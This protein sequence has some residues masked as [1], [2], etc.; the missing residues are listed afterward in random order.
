[1]PGTNVWGPSFWAL[2][3]LISF[4]YPDNPSPKDI[5]IALT[6]IK[7]IYYVL[8]CKLC[9]DHYI[10]NLKT[11]PLKPCD[12]KSKKNFVL[13]FINFHNIV[14]KMLDKRALTYDE[15]ITKIKYL[16]EYKYTHLLMKVLSKVHIEDNM[17]PKRK[18]YI[19]KFIK[20]CLYFGNVTIKK[21]IHLD[22]TDER[23]YKSLVKNLL[24]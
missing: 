1:M 9:S 16:S 3:H 18:K 2:F 15:A 19:I 13:W 24:Q 14:N 8:P 17:D 7:S 11:N 4:N 21:N 20:C 23:T 5:D 10:E 6:L 12:V 22:F